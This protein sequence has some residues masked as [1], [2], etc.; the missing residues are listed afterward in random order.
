MAGTVPSPW[1][2][3]AN[4]THRSAAG[5]RRPMDPSTLQYASD[6]RPGVGMSHHGRV[7]VPDRPGEGQTYSAHRPGRRDEAAATGLRSAQTLANLSDGIACHAPEGMW[8]VRG[9]KK[10]GFAPTVAELDSGEPIAPDVGRRM[11]GLR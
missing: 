6:T 8:L 7:G 2:S 10:A 1:D 3:P 5:Y 4:R 11:G 9:A